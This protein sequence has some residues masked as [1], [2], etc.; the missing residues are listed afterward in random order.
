[1]GYDI[2]FNKFQVNELSK[3]GLSSLAGNTGYNDIEKSSHANVE[4]NQDWNWMD[5]AKSAPQS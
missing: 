1:M 3:K 4:S 5:D 2:K